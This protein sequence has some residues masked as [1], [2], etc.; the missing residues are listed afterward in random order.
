MDGM[1]ALKA[2]LG[3]KDQVPNDQ[4]QNQQ[5]QAQN[6]NQG[7]QGQQESGA[8]SGQG[9]QGN[10]AVDQKQLLDALNLFNTNF[11]ELKKMT[12]GSAQNQQGG[13]QQQQNQGQ[14][15]NQQNQNQNQQQNGGQQNQGQ[16]NQQATGAPPTNTGA[17]LTEESIRSMGIKEM[18]KDENRKAIGEYIDAEFKKV[19]AGQTG[20]L[21]RLFN[22]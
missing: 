10:G 4:A 18:Q 15:Q 22:S 6:Q 16:N 3:I 8:G 19:N 17:G 1:E 2:L 20:G 5:G 14:N 13:Q 12:D 9:S 21:G 11:A 7:A